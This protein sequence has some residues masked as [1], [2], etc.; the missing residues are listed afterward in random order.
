MVWRIWKKFWDKAN[1]TYHDFK[2]LDAIEERQ[3]EDDG[4]DAERE[5]HEEV[6]ELARILHDLKI[7]DEVL[8]TWK[9]Q[10]LA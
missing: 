3:I 2:E 8:Q 7:G 9:R 5:L 4:A 1:Q 10:R 6:D